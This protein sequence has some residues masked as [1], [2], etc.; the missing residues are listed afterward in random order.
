MAAEAARAAKPLVM[1]AQKG[2]EPADLVTAFVS[3]N[4]RAGRALGFVPVR[5][6]NRDFAAV[7]DR[8]SGA[9]VGYLMIDPW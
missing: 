5:A 4:G 7:V 2:K 1:L 9:I 6:R 3:A 8:N